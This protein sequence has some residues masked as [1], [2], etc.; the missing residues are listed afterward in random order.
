MGHLLDKRLSGGGEGHPEDCDGFTVYHRERMKRKLFDLTTAQKQ[1]CPIER[2]FSVC[3][4]VQRAQQH[5]LQEEKT[6]AWLKTPGGWREICI[7]EQLELPSC[8]Q[9]RSRHGC[10]KELLP[11]KCSQDVGLI[12]QLFLKVPLLY[13]HATVIVRDMRNGA[14]KRA[15]QEESQRDVEMPQALLCNTTVCKV[16]AF[17]NSVN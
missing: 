3:V 14:E 12:Q 4:H 7:I 8:K 13:F 6:A 2:L 11:T 9:S 10:Q 17:C 15:C 16:K 5:R 1:S